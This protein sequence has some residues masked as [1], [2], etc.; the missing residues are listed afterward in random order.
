MDGADLAWAAGF[1]DGEGCISIGRHKATTENG[2][3]NP[4]HTLELQVGNTNLDVLNLLCSMFGGA[5][6][7]LDRRTGKRI[8]LWRCSTRQAEAAIRKL[9]PYLKVKRAEAEL[10]LDFATLKLATFNPGGLLLSD[11]VVAQREAYYYALREL[12]TR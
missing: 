1:I 4:Q 6:C 11:E 12:K 8:W 3:K 9:L 5:I 7:E 10:A 2:A